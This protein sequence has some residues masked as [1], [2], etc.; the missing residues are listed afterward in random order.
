MKI[1]SI[2]TEIIK[3]YFHAGQPDTP[4][5]SAAEMKDF[6]D[7]MPKKVLIPKINELV[8]ELN[9]GG[10]GK[11]AYTIACEQ[12]FAG[13]EAEWLKSLKGETGAQGEKGEKGDP[14]VYKVQSAGAIAEEGIYLVNGEY[15]LASPKPWD[16]DITSPFQYTASVTLLDGLGWNSDDSAIPYADE[17]ENKESLWGFPLLKY[18]NLSGDG[19]GATYLILKWDMATLLVYSSDLSTVPPIYIDEFDLLSGEVDLSVIAEGQGTYGLGEDICGNFAL[20]GKYCKNGIMT[21][22][23]VT[24][25]S[26]FANAL[27]GK[28]T[29][30]AVLLDDVS[31]IEHEIG[32]SVS[33]GLKDVTVTRYGKNIFDGTLRACIIQNNTFSDY[34]NATV[35]SELYQSLKVY[36]TEGSYS[37]NSNVPINIVR[38]VLDGNY[39]QYSKLNTY[40]DTFTVTAAGYV[41]FTFRRNDEKAWDFND[42][43][44]INIGESATGYEV[45][46]EPESFVSNSV[47]VVEGIKSLYPSTTLIAQGGEELTAE[48]NRDINKVIAKL[49][50]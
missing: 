45:Y 25:N 18:S 27:R 38:R 37:I 8:D 44:W 36:L 47:G 13:T 39:L 2:D 17:I 30:S 5:K 49:E 19:T 22:K 7:A 15:L 14:V 40:H 34:D 26:G 21:E 46:A 50:G 32:V 31:P 20:F 1:Q 35:K 48:Y 6:F 4:Q 29:A 11:S 28:K 10:Y 42:K 3:A 43:I 41:G 12:G 33:G 23:L 24:A 9:S 16:T